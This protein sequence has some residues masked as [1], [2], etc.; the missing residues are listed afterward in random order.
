MHKLELTESGRSLSIGTYSP[1][2][3]YKTTSV[4]EDG[5]T[6][7]VFKNNTGQIILERVAT[8]GSYTNLD[9]Y[10]VYDASGNLVWIVPPSASA[11]LIGTELFSTSTIAEQ[12]CYIWYYDSSGLLTSRKSPSQAEFNFQYG[13][14]KQLVKCFSGN[15]SVEFYYDNLGRISYKNYSETGNDAISTITMAEY[16]YDTKRPGSLSFMEVPDIVSA[17]DVDNRTKGLLTYEKV[18]VLDGMEMKN[19]QKYLDRDFY[20]DYMA[21]PIQI[22]EQN[23]LKGISR[24]SIKYTFRGEI[25]VIHES[26]QTSAG[27]VP[28]ILLTTF[29]FDDRGRILTE[30]TQLNSSAPVV[31]SYSYNELGQLISKDYGTVASDNYSYNIQGQL[32]QIDNEKFRMQL[33][34]HDTTLAPPS[35]TGNITEWEWQHKGTALPLNSYIAT[36]DKISRLTSVQHYTNGNKQGVLQTFNYDRNGNLISMRKEDNSLWSYTLSGNRMVKLNVDGKECPFAYDDGGN[37]VQDG[38]ENINISY[39][40]FNLPHSI[41][42]NSV[43]KVK[44]SRTANGR[45]MSAVNPSRQGYEYLGSLIYTRNGDNI[46]L[47]S[48]AFSSGR[49][50]PNDVDFYLSDHLGSPRVILNKTG[51]ET[52]RYDYTPFGEP[53]NPT[54]QASANRFLFNGKE[55]QF[56]FGVDFLDY[57]TRMYDP[58]KG[59]WLSQDPM[60]QFASPYSFSGNNPFRFIDPTGLF[61]VPVNGEDPAVW[62]DADGTYNFYDIV[63]RFQKRV[64]YSIPDLSWDVM[65]DALRSMA[66][67]YGDGTRFAAD[68]EVLYQVIPREMSSFTTQELYDIYRHNTAL[69]NQLNPIRKA[70]YSGQEAFLRGAGILAGKGLQRLGSAFEIAGIFTSG[71]LS[72]FGAGV[73][74]IGTGLELAL[75]SSSYKTGAGLL[76]GI[77]YGWD[78]ALYKLGENLPGNSAMALGAIKTLRTVFHISTNFPT[79]MD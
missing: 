32:T 63:V 52:A 7:M 6:T 45:K 2:T 20:Y 30:T 55:S 61:S 73:S 56:A 27:A 22:V 49:I 28:D 12:Y 8:D 69:I 74:W 35:Y 10:Y 65:N 9:T 19:P 1:N 41:T 16:A 67:Y 47:E 13:A 68:R 71:S 18:V 21:R 33:R 70:V 40:Y 44:Y 72:G 17:S 58:R 29:T 25:E 4:D 26:H 37:R 59:N 54:G 77:G 75:A 53:F 34:Y 14:K 31:I 57:D 5:R 66:G 50:L 39:S 46:T 24:Y 38:L 64:N 42:Q 51:T 60:M 62:I 78:Y 11:S 48:A 15:K 43:E 36:Y 79:Y 3:S 23:H 76:Q